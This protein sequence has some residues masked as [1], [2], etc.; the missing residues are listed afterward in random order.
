MHILILGGTGTMS[1]WMV[2]H[3][4]AM[5]RQVTVLNR[6]RSP[7]LPAGVECLVADR[8]DPVALAAVLASTIAA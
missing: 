3:L 6:G 2:R 1:L 5:G 4:L 7:G 8:H